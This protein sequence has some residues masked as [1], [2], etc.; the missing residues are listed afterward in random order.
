M[1]KERIGCVI[2]THNRREMLYECLQKLI[3]QTYPIKK[4]FIIDNAS[5]DNTFE[6]LKE[7]RIFLEEKEI[8][9]NEFLCLTNNNY[10]EVYYYFSR[11]NLGGAGGF[12]IGLKKALDYNFSWIWF[13]DDDA[14]P[15][16]DTLEKLL[17]FEGRGNASF[18]APLVINKFNNEI[19]FRMH[20]LK[21][22][23][24]KISEKYI[25]PNEKLDFVYK[26]EANSFVGP[27]VNVN[28]IKKTGLIDESYFILYDDT[29]FT[30]RLYKNFGPG[31]LITQSIIYH[32]DKYQDYTK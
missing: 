15:K 20:K 3:N 1:E 28:A 24:L 17:S 27:L 22:D 4:I 26:L 10:T 2:V 14:E 11:K 12:N 8:E 13:M 23:T 5:L 7:K 21:I 32:I 30:Y 31:Y 18:L 16:E 19:E 6:Y 29:D 25:N 9:E